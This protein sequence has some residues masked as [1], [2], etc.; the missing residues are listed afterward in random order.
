MS[1]QALLGKVLMREHREDVVVD[2]DGQL[3]PLPLAALGPSVHRSI[4]SVIELQR[5]S[6]Q[7]SLSVTG[8]ECLDGVRSFARLFIYLSIYFGT[9]R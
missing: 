8:G 5:C 4:F 2:R 7:D 9:S 3:L 6:V 1:L